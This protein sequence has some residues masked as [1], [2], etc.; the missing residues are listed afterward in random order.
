MKLALLTTKWNNR[1]NAYA[2]HSQRPR[3]P[4]PPPAAL[5]SALS[6]QSGLEQSLR[7]VSQRPSVQPV[8]LH[9]P[10]SG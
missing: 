8:S 6:F 9:L 4:V 10:G 5:V 2:R 7:P 3:S 1:L